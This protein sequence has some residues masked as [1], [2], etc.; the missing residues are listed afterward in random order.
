MTSKRKRSE[1]NDTRLIREGDSIEEETSLR[2]EAHTSNLN[3]EIER[4]SYLQ[5]LKN[6]RLAHK[7]QLKN[8]KFLTMAKLEE[9][10]A[11]KMAAYE[12]SI[13]KV[14]QKIVEHVRFLNK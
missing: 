1:Q 4:K 7:I 3:L 11:Q 13:T 8:E 12:D 9:I 6:L 5:H 14:F 2:S 10:V